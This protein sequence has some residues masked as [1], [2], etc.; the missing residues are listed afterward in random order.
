MNAKNSTTMYIIN[1]IKKELKVSL[2][3]K[4]FKGG[5]FYVKD[6]QE[7]FGD[8]YTFEYMA[9]EWLDA[10]W[11]DGDIPRKEWMSDDE[12]EFIESKIMAWI[13]KIKD[14][15]DNYLRGALR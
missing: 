9:Q 13:K 15:K 4:G 14:N 11:Y 1:K 3:Y 6:P 5:S 12:L 10:I 8:V 7:K 2:E